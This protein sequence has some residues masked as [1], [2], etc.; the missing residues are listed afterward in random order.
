MISNEKYDEHLLRIADEN[1]DIH[2]VFKTI[3]SKH[4]LQE[5]MISIFK[6]VR[7]NTYDRENT[8]QEQR[9]YLLLKLMEKE[10]LEFI[11]NYNLD[12][13]T[14][15]EVNIETQKAFNVFYKSELKDR[16][17]AQKL[18][19]HELSHLMW[20]I[21]KIMLWHNFALDAY[22]KNFYLLAYN[23]YC[24]CDLIMSRL[25]ETVWYETPYQEHTQALRYKALSLA[26]AIWSYDAENILLRKHV[27]ELI[28]QIMNKQ[29]L[30][31]TQVDNWL[32]K[33]K[34][35]PQ[36]IIERYKNNDYGNTKSVK[37][38]REI[39]KAEIM[40]M[41]NNDNC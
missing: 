20:G 33:S 27:A 19:E 38:Q 11:S 16:E 35:V 40:Y 32:K 18:K 13:S 37:H 3:I 34:V 36:A 4:D 26:K 8:S 29:K 14:F 5:I 7:F 22:S 25:K 6:H 24:Y 12:Y 1:S 39:L 21:L 28:I 41:L 15:S 9:D 17:L 2:K 31:L 30:S 23:N 10:V